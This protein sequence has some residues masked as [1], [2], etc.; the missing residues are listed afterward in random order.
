VI[1]AAFGSRGLC[2]DVV[3]VCLS[4]HE[5]YLSEAIL[6][7]VQEHLPTKFKL[8]ATRVVEIIALLRELAEI[9]E[10]ANVPTGAC[11][12]AK[13]LVILGTA[14]S[15][16]ADCLVT[17]DRDLLDLREYEGIGIVSP[18]QFHGLVS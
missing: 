10:P 8:P 6:R 12:D 3:R 15:A 1:V 17:G 2:E 14:V 9:V 5:I 11:R 18:R 4:R 16:D 7:E 13:D